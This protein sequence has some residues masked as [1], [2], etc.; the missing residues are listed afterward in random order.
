MNIGAN[1]NGVD[2]KGNN[3]T[4]TVEFFAGFGDVAVVRVNSDRLGTTECY[5]SDLKEQ[6]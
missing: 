6:K 2:F 3:V 4:G 1:V 5:V